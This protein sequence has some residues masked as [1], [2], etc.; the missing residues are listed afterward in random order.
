MAVYLDAIT[1]EDHLVGRIPACAEF[2]TGGNSQD[3]GA[4]LTPYDGLG[5]KTKVEV[6]SHAS[7]SGR[8][9]RILAKLGCAT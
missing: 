9:T 8:C 4:D 7:E 2:C 1:K 6:L 3:R 5:L